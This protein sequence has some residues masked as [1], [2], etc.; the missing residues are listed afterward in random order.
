[1]KKRM[2]AP[3]A[4]LPRTEAESQRLLHELEVYRIEL[5]LQNAEL[6]RVKDEAETALEKYKVLQE[7]EKPYASIFHNQHVVMF[8]VDPE[9]GAI[10]NPNPA[11]CSFYGYSREQFASLRISDINALP[12]QSV[13]EKMRQANNGETSIFNFPH[14]LANGEIRDV[15]IFR[16]RYLSRT[17]DTLLHC[18]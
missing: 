5:E 6:R 16:P 9:T 14:R 4:P 7:S 1:M 18:P 11:A 3:S 12:Q 17:K 13:S 15:S 10:L 8:L 2:Q